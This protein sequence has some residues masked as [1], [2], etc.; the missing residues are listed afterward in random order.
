MRTARAEIPTSIIYYPDLH[1]RV[2]EVRGF[3]DH[4]PLLVMRFVL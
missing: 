4:R 3:W 1:V 2:S